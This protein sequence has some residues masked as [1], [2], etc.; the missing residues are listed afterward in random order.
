MAFSSMAFLF[1][2]LPAAVL[3]YFLIPA[4]WRGGRN[5]ALLLFSLI[6]FAW[7]GLRLL[8]ALQGA[9]T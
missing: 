2:F 8:P 1:G 5:G 9:Y 4:R 3:C 6:F 7:G